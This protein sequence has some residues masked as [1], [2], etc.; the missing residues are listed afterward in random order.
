MR[1]SQS[2]LRERYD[3]IDVAKGYGI[4]F[5][6]WAHLINEGLNAWIYSFH[7]PLFFFLSGYV[8]HTKYPFKEFV[9]RKIKTL[10]VPYFCLGFPMVIFEWLRGMSNKTSQ[11]TFWEL[12]ESLIVQKRF[13]TLWYLACLFFL[14]LIFYGLAKKVKDERRLLVI[15]FMMA[16]A[17]LLYYKIGGGSLP[18]NVDTCFMAIPFFAGGYWYKHHAK[19]IE[20]KIG[21]G[22]RRGIV[23]IG[24]LIGNIAGYAATWLLKNEGLEMFYNQ[25]G[26]PVFT[27]T[28]AFLGIAC[29]VM[30][31]KKWT[32]SALRYLGEHSM[33]YYAWHQAIMIPIVQQLLSNVG[34]QVSYGN[35]WGELVLYKLSC[36]ILILCFTTICEYLI[37]KMK[38]QF[39]LGK[40]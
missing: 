33:L 19:E 22:R 39:I 32:I 17:G 10:I 2:A 16:V 12:L 3:W 6:I 25:Y 36:V 8:F 28:S 30:L 18:W 38:L 34:W 21:K 4:L 1:E 14:N 26:I 35:S 20:E 23:F 7:M 27:Y 15:S 9:K 11:N 5:V 29:M 24:C 13:Q 37:C 31:A 40:A